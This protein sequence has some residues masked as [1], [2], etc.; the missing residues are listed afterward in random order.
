VVTA[1]TSFSRAQQT[2]RCES[3][4][5]RRNYCNA[6][7][8]GGVTMVRQISGASCIQGNTWGYDGRGSWVDRGCRAEFQVGGGWNGG[9]GTIRCESNNGRR[10]Y[11]SADTRGGVTMIRQISGAS[12]IQGDTWGYDGRGIWVDRGCRAEFQVGRG[13]NGDGGGRG[14]WN[15]P[16]SNYPRVKVDTSG[17][18]LYN[19]PYGNMV[20]ITRGYVTTNTGQP[21]VG[22]SG[23]NFS[24]AFYGEV[25]S[26]DGNRELTLQI[27]RTDRGP[28]NGTASARLNKDRNEVETISINGSGFN[29]SFSR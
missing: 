24:L 16:V 29:G 1:L 25:I 26:S 7:T 8:R 15:P 5:G 28:A 10:N 20:K 13:W 21:S 17:R 6:D 9:G 22:L 2:I 18:G 11:C 3:N 4:D 27:N 19:G 12:C 23:P 14:P